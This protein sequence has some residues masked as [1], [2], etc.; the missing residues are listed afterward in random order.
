MKTVKLTTGARGY[1]NLKALPEA[2]D[3]K[4]I[5]TV[6]IQGQIGS[7]LLAISFNKGEGKPG[8][9]LKKGYV[10][11]GSRSEEVI[12]TYDKAHVE[13]TP[14]LGD[15]ILSPV[16]TEPKATEPAKTEAVVA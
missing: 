7:P 14:C 15:E 4:S 5:K 3:F 6:V 1:L 8:A 9:M 10:A 12:V 13:I 16:E 2:P 11:C